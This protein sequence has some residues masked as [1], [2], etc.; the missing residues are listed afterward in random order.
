MA[1]ETGKPLT[2]L[3]VT[4]DLLANAVRCLAASALPLRERLDRSSVPLAII[5]RRDFETEEQLALYARV[6]L[7][8][9]QLRIAARRPA[10]RHDASRGEVPVFALEATA[11][12]I[13]D[14]ERATVRRALL[15]A[16]RSR[17]ARKS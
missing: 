12:H 15:V 9:M 10:D 5:S 17:P 2:E 1:T 13:V 6:E 3:L 7:G 4:H 16:R 11:S 8:L 14:L